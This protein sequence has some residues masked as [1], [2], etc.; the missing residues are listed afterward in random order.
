MA[1]F[2]VGEPLIGPYYENNVLGI[3]QTGQ[4]KY[5]QEGAVAGLVYALLPIAL[6]SREDVRFVKIGD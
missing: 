3:D 4:G 2:K 6:G 5:R 1:G